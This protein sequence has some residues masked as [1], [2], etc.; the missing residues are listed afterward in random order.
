VRGALLALLLVTSGLVGCIGTIDDQPQDLA[1]TEPPR[2]PI[3]RST[4]GLDAAEPTRRVELADGDSFEL[5]ASYVKHDPGTGEPIRMMAYNGQIPGP[6]L[7]LSE[8]AQVDITFTNQL[9]RPTTVHWHG[10]RLDNDND[11]VPNVTQ[12]PVQPG[13]TFEYTIEVPDAG[14]FWYHPH[15]RTDLQKEL[16]LYGAI[17]VDPPKEDTETYPP[18]SVLHLDDIRLADGDVPEMYENV[19]TYAD[20]GRWGNQPFVNGT[21]QA[22]LEVGPNQ[23]HRL[24]LVNPSNARTWRLNFQGFETVEKVAAGPSY[25]EEPREIR[26]LRL[27]PAERATVDVE[28]A[29]DSTARI[30]DEPTTWTLATLTASPS[31]TDPSGLLAREA[32]SGPHER[33]QAEDRDAFLDEDPDREIHLRM[34]RNETVPANANASG[35]GHGDHQHGAPNPALG[36]VNPT[37]TS[38]D[39][40]WLLVDQDTGEAQPTYD[41][42]VGDVVEFTVD[43]VHQHGEGGDHAAHAPVPH[44]IHLHGQ[45]F[46]VADYGGEEPEERVWKD[47]V[48]ANDPVRDYQSVTIQVEITNPGSWLVHCHVSEHSEVGM[49]ALANVSE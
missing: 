47:T 41:F 22:E 10:L 38:R 6:E 26:E 11:G 25:L 29:A 36:E 13:E 48:L 5:T 39:M 14:V 20:S 18:E 15:V 42:Q 44:P 46:L 28:L 21:G 8:G 23:R 43:I 4:E 3:D 19:T 49:T 7:H 17:V 16:G 27:G 32:P 30:V 33:A 37:P 40:E 12:D 34:V 35:D 24:H 31:A 45:R 2:Q 1:A 9:D